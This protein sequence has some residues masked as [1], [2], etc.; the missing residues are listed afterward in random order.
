M[1]K[2]IQSHN[3]LRRDEFLRIGEGAN[4]RRRPKRH[5]HTM[6]AARL[7]RVAAPLLS[8]ATRASGSARSASTAA[9]LTKTVVTSVFRKEVAA[10]AGGVLLAL[11]FT[12]PDDFFYYSF[13]TDKDPDAIIDF[14]STEDFLQILGIFPIAIHFVLAG[15]VWDTERDNTNVVYNS[16]EISFTLEEEEGE[17]ENGEEIV[18]FFQKRERFVNWIP[19][20]HFVLWDQVQ[21][22]GFKYLNAGKV[23]VFHRGEYFN[24]PYLVRLGILLHAKYVIWATEKHINSK[25]FA[26]DDLEAQHEQRGNIPAYVLHQFL[27]SLGSQKQVD[28]ALKEKIELLKKHS[29]AGELVVTKRGSSLQR[30]SSKIV[31]NDASAQKA[32]DSVLRDLAKTSSG[33]NAVAHAVSDLM[34]ETKTGTPVVMTHTTKGMSKRSSAVPA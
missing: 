12:E 24:G 14:Y 25:L 8:R 1:T 6:M 33:Q 30:Q 2:N 5:P 18:G 16:M 20:T 7:G 31:L 9:S 29:V 21:C 32:L 17:D 4:E 11:P 26:T 19:L 22:Y 3:K 15:V 27:D 28:G 34:G 23:E 13:T 10:F